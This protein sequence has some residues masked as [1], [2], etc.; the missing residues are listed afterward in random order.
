MAGTA[1][2]ICGAPL[3]G[4][5]PCPHCGDRL[6][7]PGERA[8]G[9]RRR[10][11]TFG[12]LAVAVTLIAVALVAVNSGGEPQVEGMLQQDGTAR[13]DVSPEAGG[14]VRGTYAS[15][16]FPPGAVQRKSVVR[17]SPSRRASEMP[18]FAPAGAAVR[19]DLPGA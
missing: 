2:E 7:T 10:M 4:N 14:V 16:E 8:G 18:G 15:V 9:R 3:D 19:V 17:L 13:G 11:V 6:T 12:V 1:C 5:G